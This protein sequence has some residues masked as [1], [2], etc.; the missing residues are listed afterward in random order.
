[1]AAM[2]AETATNVAL[3]LLG[4]P[5][6]EILPALNVTIL[7]R[8]L[9]DLFGALVN[10]RDARDYLHIFVSP[11]VQQLYKLF[12]LMCHNQGGM[13]SVQRETP[14]MGALIQHLQTVGGL[15]HLA[16][17]A[18]SMHAFL[19]R[20]PGSGDHLLPQYC[21]AWQV[22]DVQLLR[23]LLLKST[24]LGEAHMAPAGLTVKV[25]HMLAHAVLRSWGHEKG[26]QEYI[27]FPPPSELDK[28]ACF[29]LV[30]SHCLSAGLAWMRHQGH[31]QQQRQ[32]RSKRHPAQTSLC[33]AEARHVLTAEWRQLVIAVNTIRGLD[34]CLVRLRPFKGRLGVVVLCY[35][36]C[37]WPTGSHVYGL[38]ML[39]HASHIRAIQDAFHKL[40]RFAVQAF[41]QN[42]CCAHRQP[43]AV[44][45]L[46]RM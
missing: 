20:Q 21:P 3:E 7:T 35:R 33:C 31:L 5:M 12:L 10:H 24:P 43:L 45:Q 9:T 16:A 18:S 41:H 4:R 25:Q 13:D 26:S 29:N 36:W 28:I 39:S 6:P 23:V 11:A 40:V 34:E 8:A 19:S 37:G 42:T 32:Q 27:P 22:S 30:S 14:T 2:G 46:E 1:M 44:Q 17:E 38:D 15:N